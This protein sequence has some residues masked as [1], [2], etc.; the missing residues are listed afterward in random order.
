MML[1]VIGTAS[2]A[3]PHL[4]SKQQPRSLDDENGMTILL[5]VTAF[6][7]MFFIPLALAYVW[8]LKEVEQKIVLL[9]Q[10]GTSTRGMIT[11]D[12]MTVAPWELME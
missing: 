1:R 11:I 5:I 12:S 6:F 9:R 3:E 8:A 4:E 10:Q 2:A 7:S